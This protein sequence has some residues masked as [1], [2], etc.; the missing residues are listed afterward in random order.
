VEKILFLEFEWRE[1]LRSRNII[2]LQR[3]PGDW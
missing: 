1:A 3:F 2:F